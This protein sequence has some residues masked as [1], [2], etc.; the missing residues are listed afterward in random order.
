MCYRCGDFCYY[1]SFIQYNLLGLH[2][3][4]DSTV[5]VSYYPGA[6]YFNLN[7]FPNQLEKIS[8]AMPASL[9]GYHE[10]ARSHE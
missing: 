2:M 9:V 3:F 8:Q 4:A 1:A 6:V 5:S 7:R 10:P